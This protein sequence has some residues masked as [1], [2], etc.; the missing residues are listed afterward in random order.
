MTFLEALYGSQFSE[1]KA[2]G[3]DGSKGRVNGNLFLTAFLILFLVTAVLLLAFL[4]PLINRGVGS[5]IKNV[6]SEFSGSA[7]GKIIALILMV[8]IYFIVNK[9]VGN[10]E[11]FTKYVNNY[12]ICPKEVR[13]KATAKLLI[14]FFMLLISTFILAFLN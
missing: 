5:V 1:I 3:K 2:Q 6:F 7:I 14:P 13:K 4:I 10:I 12:L 11:S 9:T 8:F